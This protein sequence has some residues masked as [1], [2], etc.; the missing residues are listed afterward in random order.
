MLL[1]GWVVVRVMSVA[2]LAACV[3]YM[4]GELGRRYCNDWLRACRVVKY[5]GQDE[6]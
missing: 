4:Y 5:T 1:A 2:V 3:E 6:L